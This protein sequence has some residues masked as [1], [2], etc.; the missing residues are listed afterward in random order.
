MSDAAICNAVFLPFL[1]FDQ[2]TPQAAGDSIGA[3]GGPELPQNRSD[4]KLDGV[5]RDIQPERYL[6]IAKP[7]R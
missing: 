5:F 2:P 4:V 3:R 6:S 1:Q 7:F